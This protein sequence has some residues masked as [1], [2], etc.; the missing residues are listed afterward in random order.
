MEIRKLLERLDDLERAIGRV[1]I[2]SLLSAKIMLDIDDVHLLTGM[3]KAYIYRLTCT[4]AIP[5]YKPNGKQIFFKRDDVEAWM[6]QNR[7]ESETYSDYIKG[8]RAFEMAQIK[9][10]G[11]AVELFAARLMAAHPEIVAG[12]ID[13]LKDARVFSDR[14][15]YTR[16]KNKLQEIS[17]KVPHKS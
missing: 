12:F 15:Y 6:Q 7:I 16:L 2:Y 5:H 8:Q 17:S 14:K 10:V 9:S 13:E 1:Q 11:D 3:S 4:R